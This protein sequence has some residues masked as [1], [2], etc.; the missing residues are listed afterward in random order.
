MR[1][2]NIK[3][4]QVETFYSDAPEYAALSHTW[5]DEEVTFQDLA[6]D[7]GRKKKGWNKILGSTIQAEKH[8]CDYV[9]IDTCCID[10]T[11]S[12]ELSEAINSMFRW[13]R[14][15][16]VCFAY[17]E[18]VSKEPGWKVIEIESNYEAVTPP[19]S[20]LPALSF[21]P[22]SRWFTRGWTLQELI[23]PK[24]V[25]FYDSSWNEIGEKRQL[26]KEISKITGID[27]DVLHDHGLLYTKSIA[28]RMSWASRR[29]TTKTEDIAYCLMGIF[30]VN[31]PL[32]YGEGERAFIRLQEV[33]MQSYY[34]HSLF[35][36]N[37]DFPNTVFGTHIMTND[38]PLLGVGLLAPH[39]VAFS[40]SADITPHTMKT[41]PYAIT[42]RGLRIRL[43]LLEHKLPKG[44][45]T[46]F[47]ILQCGYTSNLGTAIAIPVAQMSA[48]KVSSLEDDF[49]RSPNQAFI[50]VK[51]SQA[52]LLESHNVY[53]LTARPLFLSEDLNAFHRCWLRN[54]GQELGI[55]FH[56]ARYCE[57]PIKTSHLD[58]ASYIWNYKSMSMT[59]AKVWRGSR[60]ALYFSKK[61]GPAFV[62]ILTFTSLSDQGG[63]IGMD[64]HIKSVMDYTK[65]ATWKVLRQ[66]VL[67]QILVEVFPCEQGSQLAEAQ[68]TLPFEDQLMTIRVKK[69]MVFDEDMFILDISFSGVKRRNSDATLES[70]QKRAK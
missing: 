63:K 19:G 28:R 64:V 59:W 50:E 58:N 69:E 41:E 2:L 20:P 13:Y 35:A 60:A 44:H 67:D 32:L 5:G 40:T 11:S 3:T 15:S 12:A 56:K 52:A 27:V 46:H 21:L 22:G 16:K 51:Y 49:Y 24:T 47:A 9:W 34:D 14:K 66:I 61:D 23:A 62:V 70:P 18:D 54:Y 10:K 53:F 1:L 65:E 33:I 6:A 39:P 68:K 25:Y 26:E 38:G 29:E 42:N 8:S 17:L 31:M 36:W 57:Y 4:F 48:L 45:H 7:S 30:D 37:H 43:R 55:R